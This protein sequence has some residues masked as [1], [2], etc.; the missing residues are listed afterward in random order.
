MTSARLALVL[1][2]GGVAGIAWETGFLL[3]VSDESPAAANV[4][5]NADVMVGTSAGATVTAQISS[6]VGLAELFDHQLAEATHELT[7][8]AGID[9]LMGLF[10]NA[11]RRRDADTAEKLRLIGK[12]AL[13]AATVPEHVRRAVIAKRLPSHDWPDRP[14]L[15][16]AIDVDT[17]EL[18]VFE[19][20]SGVGLVDAVA[21]SCAVP[22]VWPPV[23]IGQRRYMDG[24]VASSANLDVV[25]GA[26]TVVML[27]PSASPGLAP[28]GRTLADEAA[29]HHG[30]VCTVFADDESLKA[31]G[32]N[33]LDPACRAPSAEAGREQGRRRAVELA[34]FF[35][36]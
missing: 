18:V 23:T 25:A 36:V 31:F 8:R 28:F 17:G 33:P 24:G 4:L 11:A 16:T 29:A 6:G 26:E 34:A 27:V 1:A 21:A 32:A 9:E 30:R 35:G 22:G 19:R 20:N 12:H 15:I 2:G 13:S 14:L 3:G 7:P 5:L 10:E